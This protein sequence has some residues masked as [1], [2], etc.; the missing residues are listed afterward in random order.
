M[1]TTVSVLDWNHCG[2]FKYPHLLS[3][4]FLVNRNIISFKEA[5]K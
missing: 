4:I 3:S 2:S 5:E 1:G